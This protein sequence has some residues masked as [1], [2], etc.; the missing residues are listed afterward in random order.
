LRITVVERN[1]VTLHALGHIQPILL[2]GVGG[3]TG[4][5]AGVNRSGVDEKFRPHRLTQRTLKAVG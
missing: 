1:E 3:Q 2:A 5:L 4:A